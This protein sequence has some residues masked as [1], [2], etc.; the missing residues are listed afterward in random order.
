MPTTLV[1]VTVKVIAVPAARLV[2]VRGELLPEAVS[3]L[4]AVAV[5]DVIS[6]PPLL[7]ALIASVSCSIPA[8]TLPILGADGTLAG[9][10]QSPAF[11]KAAA[12]SKFHTPLA[13]P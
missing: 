13:V 10:G 8:V 3:P 7:P 12:S 11:L 9:I 2:T 6:K 1:A 4:E 5:N